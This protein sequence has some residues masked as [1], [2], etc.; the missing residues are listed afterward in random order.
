VPFTSFVRARADVG[1]QALASI[2]A[3]ALRSLLG[4]TA[5]AVAVVTVASVVTALDGV[6]TF[7][8]VTAARAFGSETFV[9]AQ[10][11]A[12]GQMSR[13]DY[14]RK[15]QRNPPIRRADVRYLETHA[16]GRVVYAPI[17]QR[18]ADVVAGGRR[19]EGASAS[20]T[21]VALERIRDLGIARGRFFS[22]DEERRAALVAVIGADI[23]EAVFPG[24]DALGQTV[25]VAGRGLIVVGVQA[26][27]GSSA[28][29][30][31]DRSVWMPLAT[32]ER[33]FGPPVTLQV[34]ARPGEGVSA[35]EAEEHARATMRARRQLQPDEADSFDI[36]TPDAARSF[37][38]RVSQRIGV[39]AI[40]I[41]LMALVAAIIVVTNTVLV[42][43]SQRMR[44]IGVRRAVGATARQIT[45]E[46]VTESTLLALIGGAAGTLLVVAVV[47]LARRA[48]GLPLV[49]ETATLGWSLAGATLSGIVAGAYPAR[50]AASI[51]V[52]AA[53]RA[54]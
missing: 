25:R 9:I 51:D 22:A 43:V 45:R 15:L 8:E 19:Y 49:L 42:S 10:V 47:A 12:A 36:V 52:V 2:R 54:E 24:L 16:A 44:E 11:G 30:S 18:P 29:V 6:A 40:P 7:A 46:V 4:A 50:R 21:G 53:L 48:S 5:I 23:A 13:R 26:R 41:S 32:F 20:G 27:L 3:N 39:A 35:L 33:L 14:A 37:V 34:F 31:L 17:A 1:R 38:F 28:G